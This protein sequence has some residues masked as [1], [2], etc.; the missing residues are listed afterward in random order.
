MREYMHFWGFSS[1][2]TN[3]SVTQFAK[4]DDQTP[5]ELNEKYDGFK[6]MNAKIL[7]EGLSQKEPWKV[8]ADAPLVEFQ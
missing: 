8:D 2:P 5:E 3:E 7:N 1:H 6:K 4:Y